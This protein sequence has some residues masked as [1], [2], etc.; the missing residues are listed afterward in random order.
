MAI[1]VYIRKVG[2]FY[3]MRLPAVCTASLHHISRRLARIASMRMLMRPA[4]H[5]THREPSAAR[6]RPAVHAAHADA[7]YSP[8]GAYITAG[9]LVLVTLLA[10]VEFCSV[11]KRGQGPPVF[12]FRR[13]NA[14]KRVRGWS[15]MLRNR[16]SSRRKLRLLV[17]CRNSQLV[18]VVNVKP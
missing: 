11:P 13:E 5:G 17:R 14:K 10:F 8:S 12:G 1:F 18:R 9:V 3:T 7:P 15:P 2:N 6:I 4:A 16:L